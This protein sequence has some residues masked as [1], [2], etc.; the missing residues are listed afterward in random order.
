[1]QDQ[2]FVSLV[3]YG[4]AHLQ[5]GNVLQYVITEREQFAQEEEVRAMLWVRDEFAGFNLHFDVDNRPHPLP[6]TP[7]PD[8]VAT[9]QRRSSSLEYRIERIVVSP[10]AFTDSI[11]TVHRLLSSKALKIPLEPSPLTPYRDLLP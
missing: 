6:L 9:G 2:A 3:R 7:P 1:M 10:S 4:R 5:G 8:R 11:E